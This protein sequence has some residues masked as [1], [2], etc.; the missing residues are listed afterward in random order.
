MY[1]TLY[2]GRN[3]TSTAQH[4]QLVKELYL[5]RTTDFYKLEVSRLD[6]RLSVFVIIFVHPNFIITS[7]YVKRA[8]HFTLG[9]FEMAGCL[10]VL[11]I[12]EYI[13]WYIYKMYR[14]RKVSHAGVTVFYTTVHLPN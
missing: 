11:L 4:V 9:R 2:R 10:I 7:L 13:S 6:S 14:T 12:G 8:I 5:Y 1:N 3:S